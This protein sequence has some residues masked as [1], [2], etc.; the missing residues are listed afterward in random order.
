M[1]GQSELAPHD[2]LGCGGENLVAPRTAW[3]FRHRFMSGL[4]IGPEDSAQAPTEVSG[5]RVVTTGRLT[6]CVSLTR[7]IVHPF[8]IRLDEKRSVVIEMLCNYDD[9]I[10]LLLRQQGPARGPGSSETT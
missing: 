5:Q 9:L 8:S 10:N 7:D 4:H 1:L 6:V 3:K 2:A